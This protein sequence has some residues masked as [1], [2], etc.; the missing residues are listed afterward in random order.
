MVLVLLMFSTG[1]VC[2]RGLMEKVPCW[3][4]KGIGKEIYGETCYSCPVDCKSKSWVGSTGTCE[5]FGCAD[6]STQ[7]NVVELTSAQLEAIDDRV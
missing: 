7:C 6:S 1:A 5:C 4:T 2:R 3:D